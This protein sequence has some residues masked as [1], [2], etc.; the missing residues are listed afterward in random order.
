MIMVKIS[1]NINNIDLSNLLEDVSAA[2]QIK[3][4]NKY[5]F[6]IIAYDR[7]ATAVEHLSSEAKDLYDDGKL[8]EIPGVGKSIAGHLKEIFSTG[9]SKHFDELFK[10]IPDAVFELLPIEGVG[11]K[12]AYQLVTLLEIKSP[13]AVSKLLKAAEKGKIEILEGFGADSQESIIKSIKEY[14]SREK[15]HLLNYAEEIASNIISWMKEDLNVREVD[16]LGSLRR[17]ASTV[18]DIDIACATTKPSITIGHFCN[19]KN[20][21]RILEKGDK[22]AS[23]IIPGNI[24]V[25]LMVCPPG[26]YGSVLQHFTGSKH[27]NIALREYARSLKPSLSLSEYGIKI[28]N[29]EKVKEFENE[30]GFYNYLGLDWIPPE[31]REDS[32]EIKAALDGKLP[33]LINLSDIKGDLQIHSDFD[34]QTSHDLGLSSMTELVKKANLLGYEYLA[35]TDHNPSMGSHNS[36]QIRSLLQKRKEIIDKVNYSLDEK[37][38]VKYVF[39][40]LEIDILSDGNIPI[41]ESCLDILDFALVSIHSSFKQT[42]K[43]ATKRVIGALSHPK[44]K[45][46]AHPTGRKLNEREGIDVDWELIFKFCLKNHKYLEINADPMRLDLPD[47]LIHEAV[48]MGILLTTGTD[49]H[50]AD[51]MDNMKYAVYVARRGWAEKKNIITAKSLEE[52]KNLLLK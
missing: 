35:L 12:T 42:K 37:Q 27:H 15:R 7:A 52:I 44:V 19:Y 10:G 31:L 17:K 45:I 25:D 13:N 39:N 14:S 4:K 33:D 32:G 16:A 48:K 38:S 50:H 51:H 18:G 24:Q 11:P 41:T 22:T 30:E 8:D 29:S 40:S 49:A 46:F 5:K 21:S 34:T 9:K 2:Y 47:Y 3:D 6:Q 20:K 1:K 28:V 36:S 23:I 26:Q 43:E